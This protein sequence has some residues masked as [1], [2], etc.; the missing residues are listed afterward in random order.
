MEYWKFIKIIDLINLY[1]FLRVFSF[2]QTF[3]SMTLLII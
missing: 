1:D 2:F 3:I